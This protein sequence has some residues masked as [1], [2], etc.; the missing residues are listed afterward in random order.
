MIITNILL[1]VIAYL[2]F[3]QNDAICAQG[4]DLL[5]EL[6]TIRSGLKIR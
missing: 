3:K 4:N 5:K 6:R 1:I 2:L